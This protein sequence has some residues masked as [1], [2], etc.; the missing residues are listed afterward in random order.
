MMSAAKRGGRGVVMSALLALALAACSS[1]DSARDV[2]EA[3]QT[4]VAAT[5]E[6]RAHGVPTSD[7]TPPAVRAGV[8][9]KSKPPYALGRT[10]RCLQSTGAT[11][12][13]IHSADPRLRALGDLAQRT[14]LSV[15]IDGR[16]LGLAF[17]D[18]RLLESLLRVPDDPYQLEVRRNALLMF[19][20]ASFAQAKVIRGCLRS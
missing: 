10:R 15:R 3:A 6:T 20:P 19:R 17:G 7:A 11:V 5:G 12:T 13:A 4:R 9:R 8:G 18:A 2:P 16:T 1:E 14:S